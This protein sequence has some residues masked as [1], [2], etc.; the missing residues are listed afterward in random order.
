MSVVLG[1]THLVS[2][3]AFASGAGLGNNQQLRK[4]LTKY[5]DS[6]WWNIP[7][8]YW[9]GCFCRRVEKNARLL[10]SQLFHMMWASGHFVRCLWGI[11]SCPYPVPQVLCL[12]CTRAI[13]CS[14]YDSLKYIC[15]RG[16]NRRRED[17][18]V[19]SIL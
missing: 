13:E 14:L 10:S 18:L 1:G 15:S 5:F 8:F 6:T 16:S 11:V 4:T 12:V 9:G 17:I 2:A 7:G 19:V 3:E